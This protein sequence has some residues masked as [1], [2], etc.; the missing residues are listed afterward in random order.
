MNQ[1]KPNSVDMKFR[2]LIAHQSTIPHYRLPFYQTVQR[3][4]P[5]WWEFE[6]IYDKK[7]SLRH[8][9]MNLEESNFNFKVKPSSGINL[10]ILGRKLSLQ[11]FPFFSLG[12]DLVIVGQA[13]NN[14]A[15]PFTFIRKLVGRPIA[16]WGQGR[17]LYTVKKSILKQLTESF[18]LFLTKRVDG[19]FAYTQGVKEYLVTQGVQTDKIFAL[20]NTI[21]IEAQ[22]NIY[23]KL[24][25][26]RDEL[27]KKHNVLDKKVILY[28]GRFNREKRVDIIVDAFIQLNNLDSG[29]VL[30][31]VGGGNPKLLKMAT[32]NCKPG[33]VKHFGV[34]PDSEIGQYFLMADVFV[35]PGSVGLNVIQ[36]MCFNLIPIVIASRYQSPE[37][38]Y[39]ND[40]NSIILPENSSANEYATSIKNLFLD[41]ELKLRLEANIWDSIKHLTIEQMAKNFISGV[42]QLLSRIYKKK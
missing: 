18:K 29:Y 21:D 1:N 36:A 20:Q 38:E 28:V 24:K 8:F 19:F 11:A 37:F 39:L 15:Y 7:E 16:Y 42:D 17:D 41:Q 4:K 26:K 3:L 13:L 40:S 12:Y 31:V 34:V 2:I 25:E 27:R 30:L 6:V 5:D 9:Y 10:D 32:D 22:R 23:W 35:A 33:S 14:I